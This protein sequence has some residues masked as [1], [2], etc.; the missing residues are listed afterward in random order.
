MDGYTSP[1]GPFRRP[2]R[3]DRRQR[4]AAPAPAAVTNRYADQINSFRARMRK[5]RAQRRRLGAQNDAQRARAAEMRDYLVALDRDAASL[6][7]RNDALRDTG[8]A[9]AQ[10]TTAATAELENVASENRSLQAHLNRL[11]IRAKNLEKKID[12]NHQE[13]KLKAETSMLIQQGRQEAQV[14]CASAKTRQQVLAGETPDVAAVRPFAGW[15]IP[16]LRG[17]KLRTAVGK[18]FARYDSDGTGEI[19]LEELTEMIFDFQCTFPDLYLKAPPVSPRRVGRNVIE[20]LDRDS[21][22][23]IDD[24]EFYLWLAAGIEMGRE[25]RDAFAAKGPLKAQL[26]AFLD[27]VERYVVIMQNQES[28]TETRRAIT[29]VKEIFVGSSPP[30]DGNG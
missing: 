13:I 5:M 4:G 27:S 20:K 24:N 3:P 12:A 29:A 7:A 28:D 17:E 30:R 19:D 22:G 8:R 6:R 11:R 18:I 26:V 1:R 16:V 14:A 2:K 10:A 25:Q 9:H 15:N 23:E 21:S